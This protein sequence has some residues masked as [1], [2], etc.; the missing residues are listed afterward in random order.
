MVKE[1]VK[2]IRKKM[3]EKVR[4]WKKEQ[5]EMK[6]QYSEIRAGGRRAV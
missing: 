6:Q 1:E 5:E 4:N 3:K 2:K